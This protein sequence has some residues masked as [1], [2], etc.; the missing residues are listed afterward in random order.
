MSDPIS[1]RLAMISDAPDI[2]AFNIAIAK[3][4]EE[5]DLSRDTVS[6]GVQRLI[7]NPQYG[8]YVVAESGGKVIGSLMVTYEWSDWRDGLYWWIQS[9]YVNPDYRGRGIYKLLH[10]F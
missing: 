1:I 3:E 10:N 2:V 5:L 6:K 4:T 8:F 9:V 7:E